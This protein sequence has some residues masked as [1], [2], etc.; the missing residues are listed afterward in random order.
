[1]K[2]TSCFNKQQASFF[3]QIVGYWTVFSIIK[4]QWCQSVLYMCHFK[5][6][7]GWYIKWRFS[8]VF[9]W[10][11]NGRYETNTKLPE[12]LIGFVFF[13]QRVPPIC[14]AEFGRFYWI[15]LHKFYENFR[16]LSAQSFLTDTIP[17]SAINIFSFFSSIRTNFIFYVA[18]T[19]KGRRH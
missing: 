14:L 12:I 4:F 7:M 18:E 1:M 15:L 13:L 19:Y 10:M 17:V 6:N 11:L 5:K 16:G 8:L 9:N 2:N 3:C